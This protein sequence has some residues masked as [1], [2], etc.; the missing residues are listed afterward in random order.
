MKYNIETIKKDTPIKGVFFFDTNIWIHVV[1]PTFSSRSEAAK[2]ISFFD[3][4]FKS[5]SAK[6]AVSSV[7]VSEIIN[8]YIKRI[9]FNLYQAESG[10]TIS[11]SD[12]KSRYRPTDHYLNHY[13]IICD[14]IDQRKDKFIFLP[15][16]LERLSLND[17]FASKRLDFND[18]IFHKLCVESGT[19]FVTDDGDFLL[20]DIPILT[21]NQN[22]YKRQFE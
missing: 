8:V 17:A 3:K 19:T 18:Y 16:P 15:D 9:A 11:A 10:T 2:Y 13:E 7:L 22:L 12:F 6:I 4:V 1:A 14:E 5:P 21:L 20:P